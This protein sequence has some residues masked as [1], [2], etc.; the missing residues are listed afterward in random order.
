MFDKTGSRELFNFVVLSR[1]ANYFIYEEKAF[2]RAY[3]YN[4]HADFQGEFQEKNVHLYTRVDRFVCNILDMIQLKQFSS[5][6]WGGGGEL[7]VFFS[8]RIM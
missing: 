1:Y 6:K 2:G 3:N 4:T 8:R 7:G 5:L